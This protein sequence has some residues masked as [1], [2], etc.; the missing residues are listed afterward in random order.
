MSTIVADGTRVARLTKILRQ[1]D[2]SAIPHVANQIRSGITP[3][4]REWQG[5]AKGVFA[6]PLNQREHAQRKL[7]SAEFLLVAALRN[8]VASINETEAYARRDQYTT[9]RRLGPLA[10]VAVSDPI[11]ITVNRYKHGLFNGL[12]G[13]VTDVSGERVQVR[14]DAESEPRNLPKKRFFSLIL[15]KR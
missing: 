7:H 11:V 3:S 6:V 8:T 13:V 1:A 10:T 2:D 14:F 4:L 15:S 12:L 5:E 9:T